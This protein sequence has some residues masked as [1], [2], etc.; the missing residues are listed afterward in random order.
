QTERGSQ[1]H[2]RRE[3]RKG[4]LV[5]N[6]AG[7]EIPPGSGTEE[8]C[9]HHVRNGLIHACPLER[10]RPP[11][12]HRPAA[13]LVPPTSSHLNRH[14]AQETSAEFSELFALVKMFTMCLPIPLMMRTTPT[15]MSPSRRA[16]S[17]RP[18]P[19]SSFQNP[20]ARL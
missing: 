20:F 5:G 17:A 1:Q 7:G 19:D 12:G 3:S 2:R 6:P 4:E 8:R 13:A 10:P 11:T 18:C 14:H 15:T 9:N 16:Y